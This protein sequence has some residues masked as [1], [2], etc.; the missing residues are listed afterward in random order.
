METSL[1]LANR[2]REI[3]LNG[4]WV[5]CTNFKAQLS[6]IRREILIKKV[7]DLNTIEAIAFHIHY[8]IHGVLNVFEGGTL[9]ISD[10]YSFD[11]PPTKSEEEWKSFLTKFVNDC[12][13]FANIIE[14]MSDEELDGDFSENKYGSKRKNINAL[15]EHGYYH[16]GQIILIK[17]LVNKK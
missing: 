10:K 12:E 7:E 6:E 16:L 15:I 14:K 8:Y 1:Q 11:F 3:F 9:N 13:K 5:V 17:N 4:E 2:F